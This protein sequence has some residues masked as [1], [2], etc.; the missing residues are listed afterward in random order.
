MIDWAESEYRHVQK[1]QKILVPANIW[2]RYAMAELL[3]DQERE[4]EAAEALQGIAT[5]LDDKVDQFGKGQPNPMRQLLESIGRSPG[6]MLSRMNY[7]YALD[8]MK[9][10]EMPQAMK[11]LQE[12]VEEDPEDADVL[13]ALYRLPDRTDEQKAETRRLIR[14]AA[15]TFRE[16]VTEYTRNLAQFQ[17]QLP[18]ES[19]EGYKRQLAMSHNQMAWLVSN[20]EGDFEAAI[21]SSH[22]SLKL[23]PGQPA[24]LDTLVVA[25]TPT[26]IWPTRSS[27]S[28]KRSAKTPT[29]PPCAGS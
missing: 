12:G 8:N 6:S 19:L 23:V 20:T 25:T 2:S 17:M 9:R 7:F 29:P 15:N 24:Y 3:H 18:A 1:T 28:G 16:Q 4:R 13:I 22:E 14:E 26:A 21:A 27:T 10:K 5:E 11:R